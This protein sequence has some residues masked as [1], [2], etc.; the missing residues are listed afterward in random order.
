MKLNDALIYRSWGD[1]GLSLVRDLADKWGIEK[2]P[3][4]DEGNSLET[5]VR[6]C[7]ALGLCHVAGDEH[8]VREYQKRVAAEAAGLP[9]YQVSDEADAG[10]VAEQAKLAATRSTLHD[11]SPTER[12]AR[13]REVRDDLLSK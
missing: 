11:L 3:E 13:Y 6:R 7:A 10:T 1:E 8:D 9:V 4:P 5:F 2:L 12:F